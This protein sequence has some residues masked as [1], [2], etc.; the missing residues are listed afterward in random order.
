MSDRRPTGLSLRTSSS[1]RA[2]LE[3]LV[4][5]RKVICML[6]VRRMGVQL[7]IA[8]IIQSRDDELGLLLACDGTCNHLS[9]SHD[10][11]L[12]IKS[13]YLFLIPGNCI[14]RPLK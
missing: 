12:L 13:Y 2:V 3:M 1:S 7:L 8:I 4:S 5:A 11:T 9:P 6:V 14:L 10:I